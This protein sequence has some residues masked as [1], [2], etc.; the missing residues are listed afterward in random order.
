MKIDFNGPIDLSG[1][2]SR[3]VEIVRITDVR[4]GN[5]IFAMDFEAY[6]T[7]YVQLDGSLFADFIN[8]DG[9]EDV[10]FA[11]VLTQGYVPGNYTITLSIAVPGGSR[12]IRIRATLRAPMG[13]TIKAIRGIKGGNPMAVYVPKYK[14]Y[15]ADAANIDFVRCDGKRYSCQEATATSITPSGDAITVNGGWSQFAK[16]FIESSKSLE[17][18]FTNAAFDMDMFEITKA[19][20]AVDADSITTESKKFTVLTGNTIELPFKVDVATVYIRGLELTSGTAAAGKFTAAYDTATKKTTLTLYSSDATVGDEV[21]VS[22]DRYLAN[23]HTVS[24]KTNTGSA[25]G[26]VTFHFPV[27]S[28]G[29]DCTESSVKG[30]VHFDIY[31]VRVTTDVP[32]DTSYKTAATFPVTFSAIDP[33]RPDGQMYKISYEPLTADGEIDT[34][35]SA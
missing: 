25:R 33:E 31:K 23:A 13:M 29:T 15:I 19:V 20:N 27:Y 21:W 14:G 2:T 35:Y 11:P 30:L 6:G 8:I 12:D 24:V 3:T 16:A 28:S 18:T 10:A 22:Y 26:K 32:V 5:I 9:E 7:P 34:N 17:A 1:G 4:P